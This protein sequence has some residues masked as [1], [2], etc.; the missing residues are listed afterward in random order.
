M[1]LDGMEDGLS[2]Y[3][4]L[5]MAGGGAGGGGGGRGAGGGGGAVAAR[6]MMWQLFCGNI[7]LKILR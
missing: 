1:A 4:A 5:T 6:E 3:R 2:F 7:N